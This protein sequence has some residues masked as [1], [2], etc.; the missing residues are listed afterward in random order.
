MVKIQERLAMEVKITFV[1]CGL[2]GPEITASIQRNRISQ[3]KGL[4]SQVNATG[5]SLSLFCE[6]FK[7]FSRLPSNFAQKYL[8]VLKSIFYIHVTFSFLSKAIDFDKVA[9]T[10]YETLRQH[11]RNCLRKVFLFFKIYST[12]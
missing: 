2:D 12:F 10:I 1:E 6:I 5:R 11:C 3:T 7:T 4:K 8:F 9:I